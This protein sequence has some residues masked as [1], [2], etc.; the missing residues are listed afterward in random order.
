M[1][2][3]E[4]RLST[5]SGWL[6]QRQWLN[7]FHSSIFSINKTP[8]RDRK[9]K[10]KQKKLEEQ[11]NCS[12]KQNL[13]P[14][15]YILT[16]V[17]ENISRKTKGSS[18]VLCRRRSLTDTHLCVC[19]HDRKKQD[20]RE[21]KTVHFAVFFLFLTLVFARW[22][23]QDSTSRFN[24]CIWHNNRCPAVSTERIHR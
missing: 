6:S 4:Q 8:A 24:S 13:F 16:C 20:E 22:S 1:A 5:D 10:P 12:L 2:C 23:D 3:G 9:K 17:Q 11:F 15:F 19:L 14:F 7:P 21:D 18:P